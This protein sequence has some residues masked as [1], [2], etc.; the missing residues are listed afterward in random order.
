M[1]D[2]KTVTK[3]HASGHKMITYRSQ[4][5]FVP[6]N[7]VFHLQCPKVSDPLLTKKTKSEILPS[8]KSRGFLPL[9]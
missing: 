8:L 5:G 7:T 6:Q 9:T 4:E 2:K 3:P 1:Q